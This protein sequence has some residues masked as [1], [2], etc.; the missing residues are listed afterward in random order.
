MLKPNH[1]RPLLIAL[2]LCIIFTPAC[3]GSTPLSTGTAPP[4]PSTVF[5]TQVV[6]QVVATLPPTLPPPT[7]TPVPLPT[8][9]LLWDPGKEP[10]YYPLAGCVASRLYKTDTAIVTTGQQVGLYAS[11]DLPFAPLMRYATPGEILYVRRGP[12]CSNGMIIW[13]VVTS[14]YDILY[15]PEGDGTTYWVFPAPPWLWLDKEPK[16]PKQ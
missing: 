2:S 5:I 13:Q 9:T 7:Q 6:I 4:P 12:Y 15:I 11:Q 1:N 14:N 16:P 8:S 3:G 10:I